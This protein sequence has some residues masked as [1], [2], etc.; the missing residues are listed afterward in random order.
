MRR[1]GHL[2]VAVLSVG[3]V[4]SAAACESSSSPS[5]PAPIP[6]TDASF[7]APQP[8]DS[9]VA[10]TN[11]PD[12]A[13]DAATITDDIATSFSDTMNPPPAGHFTYG[14]TPTLGGAFTLYANPVLTPSSTPPMPFWQGTAT[15][16]T[17]PYVAKNPTAQDLALGTTATIP[18]G[19]M[20]FHPG[21]NGENSVIR[22]TCPRAGSWLVDVAFAPR[23]NATTSNV[24]VLLNGATPALFAADVTVGTSPTYT[25]TMTLK[26]GDTIDFAV[27]YGTNA[28]YISDSTG[29][30]GSLK[31]Q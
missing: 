1:L 26:V 31:S 4:M 5:T 14:T 10:D 7:D 6:G 29:I 21:P 17:P 30:Q 8:T 28:T 24:A 20:W 16:D 23:D 11:V 22:W 2:I 27:G 13:A 12:D 9:S 19:T 18:A 3:G 25:K 15:P